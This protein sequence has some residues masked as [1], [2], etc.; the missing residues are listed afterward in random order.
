MI[1]GKF[2]SLSLSFWEVN[3]LTP[4][5]RV[6]FRGSFSHGV[7]PQISKTQYDV[8]MPSVDV[9]VTSA[10]PTPHHIRAAHCHRALCR[11]TE[12]LG[13]LR[14]DLDAWEDALPD[15]LRSPISASGSPV[16]GASSLHL[17]FLAVKMLVCRVELHVCRPPSLEAK[18]LELT[19]LMTFLRKSI[20]RTRT[21]QRLVG[22]SRPSVVALLRTSFTSSQVC[23]RSTSRNSGCLVS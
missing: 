17:G 6:F 1:A 19:V 7:P 11:L 3:E 4:H 23:S 9:L 5:R 2:L 18:K 14:T 15:W 20:T 13:E 16:S 12:I 22:T 10:S 8:P 21:T